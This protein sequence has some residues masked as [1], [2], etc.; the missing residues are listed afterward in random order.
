[1]DKQRNQWRCR[2]RVDLGAADGK[3]LPNKRDKRQKER[4]RERERGNAHR[5]DADWERSDAEE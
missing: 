5:V 4:G 3:E 2:L 1:M